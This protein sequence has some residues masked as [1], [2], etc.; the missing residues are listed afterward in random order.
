MGTL[1]MLRVTGSGNADLIGTVAKSSGRSQLVSEQLQIFEAKR[2]EVVPE[3]RLTLLQGLRCDRRVC[4]CFIR[5]LRAEMHFW[6]AFSSAGDPGSVSHSE[7]LLS[8]API[9]YSMRP[10]NSLGSDSLRANE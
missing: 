6:I 3:F 1:F 2:S 7:Y 9:A 8:M 5:R 4:S 10:S